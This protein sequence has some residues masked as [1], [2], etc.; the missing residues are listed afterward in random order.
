MLMAAARLDVASAMFYNGST[1]PANHNGEAT[2]ITSV[3]EGVGCLC[4]G[5]DHRGGAR[6]D[7][8]DSVSRRGRVWRHVHGQ[9]DELIAEAI[10]MS[11]PG[12]ASPPAIDGRRDDDARRA[13]EAVVT[14]LRPASPPAR[15]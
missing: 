14:Q 1:M 4:A 7:R 8:A 11:I 2:D 6:R 5:Q 10:G 13:G 3:F 12:S 15:S 9:H